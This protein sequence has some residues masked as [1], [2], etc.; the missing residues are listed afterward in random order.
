MNAE[1]NA[2]SRFLWATNASFLIPQAVPGK[3]SLRSE[4]SVDN[5]IITQY[6]VY[7][8]SLTLITNRR[9]YILSC[10]T[11]GDGYCRTADDDHFCVVLSADTDDKGGRSDT[12]HLQNKKGKRETKT[13]RRKI[14]GRSQIQHPNNYSGDAGVGIRNA[15]HHSIDMHNTNIRT[16]KP[17]HQ[18]I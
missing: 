17:W 4:I 10:A 1:E 6:K 11:S 2:S 9:E 8:K 5:F 7:I 12:S 15:D 14:A 3:Y 16:K 13:K 18:Q